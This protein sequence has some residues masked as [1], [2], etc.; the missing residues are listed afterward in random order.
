[1]DETQNFVNFIK[2]KFTENELRIIK[3]IYETDLLSYSMQ[4]EKVKEGDKLVEKSTNILDLSFFKLC[5][6]NFD[7]S[8]DMM[9]KIFLFY[10]GYTLKDFKSAWRLNLNNLEA[11]LNAKCSYCKSAE[12]SA[13]PFKLL[14]YILKCI[15]DNKFDSRKVFKMLVSE[16][17]KEY[18]KDEF[19]ISQVISTV[20]NLV[21]KS[22]D[23][24]GAEMILVSD[25]IKIEKEEN[26]KIYY[27]Y[28]DYNVKTNSFF[29][30]L[31]NF[32]GEN[33]GLEG[34][35]DLSSINI[36]ESDSYLFEKSPIELAVYIRYLCNRQN[37]DEEEIIKII[38][39]RRNFRESEF[40]IAYYNQYVHLI[41]TLECS[42]EEKD[43]IISI[44]TY[45]RNYYY[46]EDIP[47]IHFN[48]A[49]YTKN[50]II[51]DKVINILNRYVRTFNYIGNKGTLWVDTE[52]L[53]KRTKDSTDM[54]SQVDK[55]Y[56]EN[57][58]IIFENMEKIKSLN[59]YRVDALF[60]AI[61]KFNN[62][63]RKSI[64]IFIESENIFKDLTRKTS[65]NREYYC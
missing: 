19:S 12:L 56:S 31:T 55:M 41:E 64:T 46:N 32:F 49:L 26:G 65:I 39:E 59:E 24:V 33:Q 47:Y 52:M 13:C 23:L 4:T 63:I 3:F 20:N 58:I 21:T 8:Q 1:M 57:D 37:I 16:N 60:T 5:A 42:K 54:I 15:S 34:V 14:S 43:E 28:L 62:K 35:L 51:A 48:I 9:E 61:E 17:E 40:K 36:S 10:V 2:E 27:R 50:N 11:D 45:I 38:L 22:M 25:S 18:S 7:D 29:D 30:N 6:K 53:V 44:L